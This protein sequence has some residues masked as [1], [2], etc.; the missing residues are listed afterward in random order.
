MW[1]FGEVVDELHGNKYP[2]AHW[3]IVDGGGVEWWQVFH[4]SQGLVVKGRGSSGLL[5]HG[6]AHGAVALNEGLDNAACLDFATYLLDGL[7]NLVGDVELVA[8]DGVECL[9]TAGEQRFLMNLGVDGVEVEILG[10]GRW[11]P[12]HHAFGH[13]HHIIVSALG[14]G[15]VL[16]EK[17][18]LLCHHVA[19]CCCQ[20]CH[21]GSSAGAVA[22]LGLFLARLER[23]RHGGACRNTQGHTHSRY[24]HRLAQGMAQ[25]QLALQPPRLALARRA[26]AR[27][28]TLVVALDGGIFYLIGA[29]YLAADSLERLA[30]FFSSSHIQLSVVSYQYSVFSKIVE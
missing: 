1:L 13:Q 2:R 19:N 9:V 23:R 25:A 14:N 24:R 8:D 12:A 30:Y 28:V 18:G 21:S 3:H 27:A 15:V 11:H 26:G 5:N 17:L 22:V 4:Y 29:R 16:S 6:V 7:E 10:L 20:F